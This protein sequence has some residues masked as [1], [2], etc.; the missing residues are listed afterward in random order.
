MGGQPVHRYQLRDVTAQAGAL[1]AQIPPGLP[2]TG[3][4]SPFQRVMSAPV[5]PASVVLKAA[6]A[7]SRQAAGEAAKAARNFLRRMV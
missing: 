4:S 3:E 1:R 5:H 6:C 7:V 2:I